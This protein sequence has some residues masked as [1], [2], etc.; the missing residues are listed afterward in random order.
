M[1][2]LADNYHIKSTKMHNLSILKLSM[3]SN[4]IFRWRIVVN[5]K[6]ADSSRSDVVPVTYHGANRSSKDAEGRVLFLVAFSVVQV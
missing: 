5:F 4:I 6:V 1:D 2:E 3:T